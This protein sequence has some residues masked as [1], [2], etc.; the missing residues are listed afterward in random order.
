MSVVTSNGVSLCDTVT[1]DGVSY[2]RDLSTGELTPMED[3]SRPVGRAISDPVVVGH[4]PDGSPVYQV[5]VALTPPRQANGDWIG[6]GDRFPEERAE[7]LVHDR[8]RGIR[9]AEF[10]SWRGD[11]WL[12]LGGVHLSSVTHWMPLPSRPLDVEA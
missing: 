2:S 12:D 9:V 4:N 6:V 10:R 3:R 8:E 11:P 7:V 1:I 5:G